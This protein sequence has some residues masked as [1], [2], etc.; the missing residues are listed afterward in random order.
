MGQIYFKKF[1]AFVLNHDELANPAASLCSDEKEK[2]E[3]TR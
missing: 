3:N 2:P 1:K